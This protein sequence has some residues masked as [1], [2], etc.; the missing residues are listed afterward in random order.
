M[1]ALYLL[2]LCVLVLWKPQ[3]AQTFAL[4][5][6]DKMLIYNSKLR[7]CLSCKP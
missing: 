1:Y 7:F 4:R 2:T 3:K 6:L 5:S